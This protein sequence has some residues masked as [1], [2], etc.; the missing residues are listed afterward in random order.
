MSKTIRWDIP[1]QSVK[2]R[3][4]HL[5]IYD[6]GWSSGRV[7]IQGGETPFTT[8]EDTNTDF[9]SP[10][11]GSTGTISI[12]DPDGTKLSSMIPD[13][14]TARPVRLL[15]KR[16]GSGNDIMWQGFLTCNTYS[17]GY[18]NRPQICELQ[19]ASLLE[20][21]DSIAAKQSDFSGLMSIREI[22]YKCIEAIQAEYGD[23]PICDTLYFP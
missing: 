19:V 23:E 4:Y 3:D 17:Q 20:A 9:F 18:T 8:S 7:T 13:N 21:A 10:V 12:L 6:D 11:R 2:G 22:I 16:A 1:F 14:N 15:G 5:L